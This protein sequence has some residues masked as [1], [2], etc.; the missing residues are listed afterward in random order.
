[1][2]KLVYQEFQ[3]FRWVKIGK[4]NAWCGLW[5]VCIMRKFLACSKHRR[6]TRCSSLRYTLWSQHT[7]A[8]FVNHT[9]IS[10]VFL[11]AR[12]RLSFKSGRCCSVDCLLVRWTAGLPNRPLV[13]DWRGWMLSQAKSANTECK[14]RIILRQF[15]ILKRK[16][17]GGLGHCPLFL[18]S[19]QLNIRLLLIFMHNIWTCW[20]GWVHMLVCCLSCVSAKTVCQPV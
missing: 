1:M 15:M 2:A 12:Q 11:P 10:D 17:G 8:V 5:P 6:S 18:S 20:F 14:G 4:N 3:D 13:L 19:L 9:F 16:M 7:P